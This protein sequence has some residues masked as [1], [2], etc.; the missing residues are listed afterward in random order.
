MSDRKLYEEN[1]DRILKIMRFE[2]TD[3]PA[4]IPG[5][6]AVCAKMAGVSM[7]DYCK[8][9][10]ASTDIHIKCWQSFEHLVDGVQCDICNPHLLSLLWISNVKVA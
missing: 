6:N 3:R 10:P 9:G 7:A 8:D 1:L 4:I 2:K 5:G